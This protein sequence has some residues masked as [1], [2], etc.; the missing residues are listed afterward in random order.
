MRSDGRV[1]PD[2]TQTLVLRRLGLI[3][4]DELPG[5]AARWLAADMTDTESSRILAGHSRHDPWG[6]DQ[7]LSAVIDEA[8]AVAPVDP[9]AIRD[10]ALAWV[11][12]TWR[13]DKDT[14]AAVRT[15]ARLGETR[16]DLDLGH[17]IG[18]DDEWAGRWGRLPPAL[19]AEA[20]QYLGELPQLA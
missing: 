18:L 6:L 15:L 13:D 7:L 1:L 2:L 9:A 11:A 19:K 16:P 14:R 12:V 20:D 17:F 8:G 5:L 4:S 10:I 3:R